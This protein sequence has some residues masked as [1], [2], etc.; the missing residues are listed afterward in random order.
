MEVPMTM[1]ELRDA[2]LRLPPEDRA[3]LASELINSLDALEDVD[4]AAVDAAWADEVRRR[5]EEVRTGNVSL[6]DGQQVF[7]E[8]R[9]RLNR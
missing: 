2:A 6:L 4:Q 5:V 1:K 9:E 8:L 3:R 7:Q